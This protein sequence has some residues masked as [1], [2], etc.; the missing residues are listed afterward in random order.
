MFNYYINEK[1]IK[2]KKEEENR[3]EKE[4]ITEIKRKS[5]ILLNKKYFFYNYRKNDKINKK[6]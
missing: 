4:K 5:K 1:N 6:L 2:E 3:K